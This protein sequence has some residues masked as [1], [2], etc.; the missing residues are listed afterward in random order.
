MVFPI[1]EKMK[2]EIETKKRIE[3]LYKPIVLGL[4]SSILIAVLLFFFNNKNLYAAFEIFLI[5]FLFYF[6]FVGIPL[7]TIYFNY[8]KKDSTTILVVEDFGQN[9]IYKN[10]LAE[11]RFKEEEIEKV[12]FYLPPPL[13]ENRATWMYWDALYYFEIIT[14]KDSFKISCL[15]INNLEDYINEEK[16][17]RRKVYFPLIK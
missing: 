13:F 10:T 4:L 9:F 12:I 1:N 15:V 16:I 2:Y 11:H 14:I 17:E 8:S 3:Y 5:I 6:I 7:F